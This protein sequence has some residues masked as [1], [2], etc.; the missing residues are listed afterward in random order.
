M[1]LPCQELH[2]FTLAK[3]DYLDIMKVKENERDGRNDNMNFR[4]VSRR[5]NT[6]KR[7]NKRKVL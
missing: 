2:P 4:I 3:E 5:T 6:I 1:L 7:E